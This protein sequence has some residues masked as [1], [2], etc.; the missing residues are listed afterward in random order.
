MYADDSVDKYIN[1]MTIGQ[2]IGQLVLMGFQGRSL[3]KQDIAHIKKIHPGGIVF[4]ARNFNDASDVAPFIEKITSV[5]KNNE[6]PMF[7][8][9]DQEGGIVHRIEGE[10]F[11]PPSA[12]SIGAAYSEEI[13]REVGRSIGSTLRNLGININLAPV[14]DMP[15]DILS[16]QMT[17]RSYSNDSKIVEKLGVAYINGLKEAGLL[18]TAKHFPGIGRANKDPHHIL[19]HI[20]WGTQDEKD[21]DIEP[22]KGAIKAGVD[23]IMV[24]HFIAE[25]GDAKNPISLSSY[26]M[27]DMLKKRYWF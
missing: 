27:K 2:K 5:F 18:S 16:S 25:P 3:N 20:A 23:I 4:Y 9:I 7:F 10:Y 11:K 12:P 26:W 17:L 8:A 1:K 24:G 19:Q 14:L 22:F 13:A 15:S 21:N 6:V